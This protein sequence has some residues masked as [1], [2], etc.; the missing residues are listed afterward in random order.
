M[1][2][3]IRKSLICGLAFGIAA[4]LAAAEG[5][6]VHV[7]AARVEIKP[8]L[9]IRLSGYQGRTSEAAKVGKPLFARALAIGGA[10]DGP[11]VLVT[12][13]VIGV[14]QALTDAVA[15]AVKQSHGVARERVA[16]LATHTHNGPAIAGVLPFMFGRDLPADEVT[17]IERFTAQLQEKAIG[18]ARAA[19]ED[20]KPGRLAWAQGKTD[21]AVQRRKIVNGK[22]TGFGVDPAGLVDHALPVLRATD[23]RGAVRAL[24]V[25]YACHCT[26]LGVPENFV[27]SDWAGDAAGRIEEA[28]HGA[29]AMIAIGC[30]ADANPITRTIAAVAEHGAKVAA[31]VARLLAAPMQPL[32]AVTGAQRRQIALPLDP[33]PTRDELE[34]RRGPKARPQT[35]Y[36][37]SK[38]IAEI[39]A[40]RALPGTVAYPVQAWTF[41][42]DLTMVFLSGE[43]VA[44]YALRLRRE[45]DGARVWVNAY[46]NAVPCYIPAQAMYPEGGYEVESSMDYYGFPTRLAIGTEDRIIGTVLE[47]VPREFRAPA[48]GRK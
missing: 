10:G 37:A 41:G 23:A 9:P 22:W 48:G 8:E 40:G 43:V 46:A 12:L 30:G 45:L 20:R 21:F 6:L 2:L 34:Q 5:P 24:L 19:L 25:N 33:L 13:E 32:G 44:Q 17:R 11:A 4:A 39:D 28:H 16:V 1:H 3:L 15:A 38:W 26:T 47:L 31:E 36:A 42:R 7:G 27:H 18:V 14:S 29:V 35:A